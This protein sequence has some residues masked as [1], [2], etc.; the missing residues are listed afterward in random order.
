MKRR[1]FIKNSSVAA[2]AAASSMGA[3]QALRAAPQPNIVQIII[4][5]LNDWVGFL[6]GPAKTPNLDAFAAQSRCYREAH[7]AVPMCLSSRMATFFSKS[8]K[9]SGITGANDDHGSSTGDGAAKALYATEDNLFTR[10]NEAGYRNWGAGKIFHGDKSSDLE[11]YFDQ[12]KYKRDYRQNIVNQ[13]RYWDG[14][15]SLDSARVQWRPLHPDVRAARWTSA[16]LDRLYAN[17]RKPWMMTS[18]FYSPHIPFQAPKKYFNMYSQEELFALQTTAR[19]A[20]ADLADVPD[21]AWTAYSDLGV[22]ENRPSEDFRKVIHGYLAAIS[23]IDAQFG[24]VMEHVRPETP[25]IMWSDHGWALGEKLKWNKQ[26]LWRNA[27]RVPLLV[28][29][30]GFTAGDANAPVSLLDVTPTILKW[31]GVSSTGMDGQTLRTLP[32]R[33]VQT[34]WQS[35]RAVFEGPWHLIQYQDG[36]HELYNVVRDPHEETNLLVSDPSR[37]NSVASSLV[38]LLGGP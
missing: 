27:T 1:D 10:L 3:T 33:P 5:D 23:F 17:S 16:K 8:P 13:P 38:P 35:A 36:S 26:A 2:V 18:G 30:P 7:C 24:M 22:F 20:R 28:R 29:G 37:Y 34:W 32:K 21:A 15:G 31:A 6:G 25:V 4:D 9:N 11:S 19:E 12:R 14:P